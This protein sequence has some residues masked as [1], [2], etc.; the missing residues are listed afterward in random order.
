MSEDQNIILRKLAEK[1]CLKYQVHIN[2]IEAFKMLKEIAEEIVKKT[3]IEISKINKNIKVEFYDKSDFE[4]QMKFAGD[5]LVVTMH[6]NV[7]EFPRD[8]DI[9]KT[10]YIKDNPSRSFCGIINV[11]NFLADSFKY[12]RVNDV[13][14]LVARLFVNTENHYFVEGKRQMGLLFNNF[15]TETID[16]INLTKI[17][18][19]AIVYCI[20]FDLL[21]PPYDAVKEV[22]VLEMIES[23]T[24]MMTK[25]GKRLGF[26]FQIDK[27]DATR[28][29]L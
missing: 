13:G 9:M 19:T 21:T 25:T 4:F 6:S 1:S 12:N 24:N 17:L 26:R 29:E 11:Y 14:Y 28:M 8:H 23:T 18:E 5:L 27:D 2:T 3:A 22:P 16:K 20:D 15:T 10:S 7:F